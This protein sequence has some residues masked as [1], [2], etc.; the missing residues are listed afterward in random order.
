MKGSRIVHWNNGL[1]DIC[2]LYG[3]GLFTSEDEY[4]ENMLRI[5]KLLKKSYDKVIFATTTPVNE[6]NIHNKNSDIRRY[7][8]LIVPLLEENGIIINDLYTTVSADID[9]YIRTDDKIHLTDAGIKVCAKQ[10]T[11]C[12]LK[13]AEDLERTPTRKEVEL[14]DRTGAPV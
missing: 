7:N 10:V 9:T 12:I 1:W 13:A 8:E 14:Y 2:N 3:D 11:D 5:A 6:Q 4:V